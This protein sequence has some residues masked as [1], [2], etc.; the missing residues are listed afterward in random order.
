MLSIVCLSNLVDISSLPKLDLDFYLW[1]V[2]A[3]SEGTTGSINILCE[4]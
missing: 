1:A 3:I 4:Y 2:F